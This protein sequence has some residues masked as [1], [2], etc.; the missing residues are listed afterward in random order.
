MDKGLGE[1]SVARSLATVSLK[2]EDRDG[3]GSV[4]TVGADVQ[5]LAELTET[6]YGQAVSR[7][8]WPEF[9]PPPAPEACRLQVVEEAAIAEGWHTISK[10]K[11]TGVRRLH[12]VGSCRVAPY[13]D[14]TYRRAG[15]KGCIVRRDVQALCQRNT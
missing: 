8:A 15:T 14:G 6:E 9:G 12:K 1:L 7:V 3:S 10:D 2:H 13:K 5:G 4:S 11:R